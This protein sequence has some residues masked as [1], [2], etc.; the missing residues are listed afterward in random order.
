MVTQVNK[1]IKKYAQKLFESAKTNKQQFE[2]E[3]EEISHYVYQCLH[4]ASPEAQKDMPKHAIN[5]YDT[6]ALTAAKKLATTWDQ[7]AMTRTSPWLNLRIRNEELKQKIQGQLG[8][9]LTSVDESLF[10]HFSSSNFYQAAN[11]FGQDLIIYGTACMMILD[12]KELE[13]VHVPP[14]QIFIE[15]NELKKVDVVFRQH[16]MTNRQIKDRFQPDD[17]KLIRAAIEQ[18]DQSKC[19]VEG[20]YP[21]PLNKGMFR[22]CV[23]LEDGWKEL[24]EVVQPFNP[25]IVARWN[26][27][28]RSAWGDSPARDALPHIRAVNS[29]KRSALAYAEYAAFGLWQTRDPN[30]SSNLFKDSMRPGA[31]LAGI[32]E[33]IEP[34]QFAGNFNITEN[35][36]MREQQMINDIFM[37]S[38]MQTNP[39]QNTYQTATEVNAR[40]Q[41]FYARVGLPAQ[42]IT[43]EFLKPVATQTMNRMYMRG[44]IASPPEGLLEAVNQMGYKADSIMDIFTVDVNAAVKKIKNMQTANNDLQSIMSVAQ[45]VG[46]ERVAAHVDMDAL[47][48]D[49]LRNM[50][51]SPSVMRSNEEAQQIQQQQAQQAQQA[52]AV[53]SIS[54]LKGIGNDRTNR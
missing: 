50:S 48:R 33:P 30:V 53:E 20:C 35:M 5:V 22:Y 15:E 43:E 29:M 23:Y 31:C 16:S 17:D 14:N 39:T 19:V 2:P 51:I 4:F 32:E 28:S 13:Y 21:D 41:D 44:D 37:I 54:K 1:D 36:I 10:D 24:E 45:V 34:I 7:L 25:F 9:F 42:M 46:P 52:A 18:P 8:A 27:N 12:G 6:T 40:R 49:L 11:N 26:Q 3:L 47:C 38:E